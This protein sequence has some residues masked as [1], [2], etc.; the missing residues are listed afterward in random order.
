M[1]VRKRFSILAILATRFVLVPLVAL[2][3]VHLR[4]SETTDV[5][6]PRLIAGIFTE[7]VMS[8]SFILSSI[9]CAKPFLKPFHSGY[10]IGTSNQ[11]SFHGNAKSDSNSNGNSYRMLSA[12]TSKSLAV[13]NRS[14]QQ[15]E[16]PNGNINPHGDKSLFRPEPVSH[17][18]AVSSQA[19][20]HQPRT[21]DQMEISQTKTWAVSYEGV[22][23]RAQG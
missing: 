12:T 5:P 13:K 23:E 20:K 19:A 2:R 7:I 16:R 21:S 11:K 17:H 4:P 1:P 9:T 18:A 6:R 22:N 14:V 3:L 10:F 15:E 8:F